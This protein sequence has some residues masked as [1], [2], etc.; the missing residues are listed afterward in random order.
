MLYFFL[1]QENDRIGLTRR[2]NGDLHF[3]INGRDQGL[4]ASGT[5]DTLYG[6]V[7]LYGMAEKVEYPSGESFL[8]QHFVRSKNRSYHVWYEIF[9]I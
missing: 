2:S 1:I 7:D 3:F 4:A 6:V 9:P 8:F 5:A